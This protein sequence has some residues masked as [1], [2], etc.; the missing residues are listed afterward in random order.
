M[1]GFQKVIKILAICF[2]IALI[3]NIFGVILS[4]VSFVIPMGNDDDSSL[5]NFSE[6]YENVE[7][8]DI[9]STA[10]NLTIKIGNEFKVEGNTKGNI[11]SKLNNGTLKVEEK[12]RWFWNN[13]YSGE[14]IIYVPENIELKDLTVDAGAGKINVD[15]I[16]AEKFDMDQ[17]A[18]TLSI[19]NSKFNKADIDGG[20]GKIEI[21]SSELNN[22]DFDA[23]AGKIDIE[24]TIT[25]DSKISAGVGEINI[26]LLGNKE[27]YKIYT[28]KG[29]GSI[30]VDNEER[31]SDT[32]YGEGQNK[33]D[34]DGGV[35][36]ITVNFK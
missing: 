14:I 24:S 20:A 29:I 27:D 18:G 33:I 21:T 5:K 2:A 12:T 8:I 13:N 30:K 31:S 26:T 23:G 22:L 16:N 19:S 11:I 9:D 34:I 36:S 28:E 15:G 17:G 3:V 4:L 35:G 1:N 6:V 25:G 32:Y 7:K 10:S